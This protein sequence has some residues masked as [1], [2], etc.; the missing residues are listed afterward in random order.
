MSVKQLARRRLAV[1]VLG[2]GMLAGIEPCV[3]DNYFYDLAAQARNSLADNLVDLLVNG[4]TDA[5]LPETDE[6]SDGE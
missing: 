3:P 5:L 6:P 4:I 2:G 1:L